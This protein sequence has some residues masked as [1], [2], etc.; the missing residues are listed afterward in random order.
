MIQRY[1]AAYRKATKTAFEFL[2]GI[3]KRLLIACHTAPEL[4]IFACSYM[5]ALAIASSEEELE[6]AEDNLRRQITTINAET[7]E[8][9]VDLSDEAREA[10]FM[11]VADCLYELILWS[12]AAM[13][14]RML[15]E[16]TMDCGAFAGKFNHMALDEAEM[17]ADR[18]IKYLQLIRG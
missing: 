1:T 2:R 16:I 11:R 6:I 14:P 12:G 4:I 9:A 18:L 15:H 3:S 17:E 8:A 13:T 5:T 10:A 7:N